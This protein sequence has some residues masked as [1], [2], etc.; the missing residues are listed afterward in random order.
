V[1]RCSWN[2]PLYLSPDGVARLRGAVWVGRLEQFAHD[3]R[4]LLDLHCAEKGR[5]VSGD[6]ITAANEVFGFHWTP[7]R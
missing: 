4:K 2:C 1:L 7:N 5:T 6:C 3:L